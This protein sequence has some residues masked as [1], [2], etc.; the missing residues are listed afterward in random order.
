MTERYLQINI[1][2]LGA[3]ATFML[4]VSSEQD[5]WLVLLSVTAATTSFVLSDWMGWCHLNR[6]VANIA[7]LAAFALTISDVMGGYT[8]SQLMGI[9]KLLV[10][11]QVILQ[12][13]KKDVRTY[14]QLIVLSLLQV[15][16]AAALNLGFVFGF[17]LVIYLFIVLSAMIL[18]LV[19]RECLPYRPIE[20]TRKAK[21]RVERRL[22]DPLTSAADFEQFRRENL[23]D[24]M[25]S[26]ALFR[27]L[28]S[29]ACLTLVGSA[30]LFFVIPRRGEAW[31]SNS[32]QR[33]V[34]FDES[35]ELNDF[36]RI[37]ENPQ[38]VM[39]V[40]F[41]KRNNEPY[42]LAEE[43][44]FRGSVL[45]KYRSGRWEYSR[46]KQIRKA[47][48]AP[49]KLYETPKD[50][51]IQE[52]V[53]ETDDRNVLFS[54]APVYATAET[55]QSINIDPL[56]GQLYYGKG[57]SA[58]QKRLRYDL[59]TTGFHRGMQKP[60]IPELLDVNAGRNDPGWGNVNPVH[61]GAVREYE[62]AGRFS[63]P[64]LK[65]LADEIVASSGVEEGDRMGTA[66]AL[67]AHFLKTGN[68]N[69]TLDTPPRSDP[70]LDPIEDFVVNT[71]EGHCEYF[72]SALALMLRS[73][74][75]P[76]RV[77]VGYLGGEYNSIGFY[78]V[79]QLHTH[80]WVEA[81]LEPGEWS[82]ADYSENEETSFGGWLRLDP[83]PS[84]DEAV[85]TGGNR[86]QFLDRIDQ[87]L[88]YG[89]L[90][91][92]DYVVGLTAETQEKQIYRPVR[93]SIER[94]TADVL[95]NIRSFASR[96]GFDRVLRGEWFNWQ[97]G[98]LTLAGGILLISTYSLIRLIVKWLLPSWRAQNS[99]R[100]RR[101]SDDVEFYFRF[102][103]L[104]EEC[105]WVRRDNVTPA[106][107]AELTAPH[108][109][110][111]AVDTRR[112]MARFADAFYRVRYGG[113][114]LNQQELGDLDRSLTE[115]ETALV[116]NTK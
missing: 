86:N 28:T 65:K 20:K 98:L 45:T 94:S 19:H 1:C 14:W 50:L 116:G 52:I 58:I 30:I 95:D 16:V 80:A 112:I 72:A 21:R 35:V 27:Q 105:G 114:K 31:N 12:F 104:M 17:L 101:A 67:E 64:A 24:A 36:G 46:D 115:L 56:T 5:H 76:S 96:F 102:E 7:A 90:F 74:G 11:L 34:G 9:A 32:R 66:R 53:L 111:D 97:A 40:T 108:I 63:Y 99:R 13:Q 22:V 85:L 48:L 71:K 110:T 93:E 107:F 4:T 6:I 23:S 75:I 8:E 100:K 77:I 83:T 42:K 15:V 87:L 39:R 38:P 70:S 2:I 60:V 62:K 29:I 26:W 84:D 54:A 106:E 10:Y 55:S 3:F 43:P 18:F 113:Q 91:W 69:Y 81:Y 103:K 109:N 33:T 82:V 59:A 41:R 78:T 51:V 44:Y 79:R 47:H 61:K 89:Q 68:Y 25:L 92:D 37:L 88:D 49:L 57:D 73:Q